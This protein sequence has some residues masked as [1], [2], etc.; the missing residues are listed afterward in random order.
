M[1]KGNN[2]YE[3]II[4][5]AIIVIFILALLGFLIHGKNGRGLIPKDSI[6]EIIYWP[7]TILFFIIFPLMALSKLMDFYRWVV[8]DKRRILYVTLISIIVLVSVIAFFNIILTNSG[9]RF[10]LFS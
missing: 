2:K 9:L 3:S 8:A 1:N 4:V 5:A 7:A 10:N 6:P